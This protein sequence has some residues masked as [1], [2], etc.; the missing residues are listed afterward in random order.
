MKSDDDGDGVG[1]QTA[2]QAVTGAGA[3]TIAS[4]TTFFGGLALFPEG[5]STGVGLIGLL[6][7]S[8]FSGFVG[9]QAGNIADTITG[10]NPPGQS[11]DTKGDGTNFSMVEVGSSAD[12]ITPNLKTNNGENLAFSEDATVIDTRTGANTGGGN[13]TGGGATPAGGQSDSLPS[14]K[15]S[16]NSNTF[17]ALANSMYNLT[18]Y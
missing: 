6:G 12:A 8:L 10:V 2:V 9:D 18:E 17:P 11:D 1:D 13:D 16:D 7:L 4:L 15:S 14:I 5:I 3:N